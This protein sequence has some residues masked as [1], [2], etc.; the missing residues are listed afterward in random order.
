[1]PW[2]EKGLVLFNMSK[3]EEVVRT[4]PEGEAQT[5]ENQRPEAVAHV[6][7]FAGKIHVKWA[8]EATVSSLATV[9]K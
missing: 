1:M 9:R 6:D 3:T 4:H 2:T 8:P 5:A 7:T